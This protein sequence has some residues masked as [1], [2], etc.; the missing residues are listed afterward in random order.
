MRKKQVEDLLVTPIKQKGFDVNFNCI[1]LAGG[2]GEYYIYAGSKENRKIVFSNNSKLHEESKPIIGRN[3]N[4]KNSQEI[5]DL[6][7]A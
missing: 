3:I 7:L 5:I 6:I 1:G 4:N 2:N